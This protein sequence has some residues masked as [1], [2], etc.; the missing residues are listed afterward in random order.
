[1]LSTMT[2][3][4]DSIRM[5]HSYRGD[6]D[7][8]D[9]S[10]RIPELNILSSSS[11]S[12][13]LS[14]S[15][16]EVL[17]KSE[18]ETTLVNGSAGDRVSS[19]GKP[20]TGPRLLSPDETIELARCAVDNGIQETKRS[21]AGSEAV[22]D[23]VKPKLTI[24]LGHSNIV[25]IPEPVV[26]IIKDEVERLSLSGNQLFHIPY[27]FAECSHLRYLNIRANNFR[28]FPKGVY[29]LPLLEI[30]D[31]SRNK[32]SQL[33]EE[34]KKLSSL[35]VLSVMQNRLDD[36]PLG[37]SD[38]NKLQIL[39]VA[40]NPLRN[41]LREL[42][43]TSETDIAPSTMTD[44]EKEVAVT[45]E[46][47][48]FLKN[49]QLSTTP[50]NEKG[51]DASEAIWDTPKPVKRGISSRF[52]VIPSTGDISCDPKSPSL[53]RPPPI[54]L[55][56]HYRI[57][58]GQGIAF[59]SI[60]PRPGTFIPGVNERNRS[61]SEGIIQASIAARSKRMGVIRKNADLGR[62]DETQ[63]YRN[64]HLRGLSHG[65]ILRPRAPGAA[66]SNSS[67]PSSPRERRRLKDSFVNRMSSLPEHKCERK[68]RESIIEC[69]KGVLFALFQVQSHVY[70]LINVIK[71]DDTRRNS[72]EIVFYNASTHVDRLNDALEYAENAQ[73]DDADLVR[74]SNE[75]VK[76]EC[77]T[78]IMA[79]TH[80][81][82]QLRNSL[83]KIVANAD[84]RYVRSLMLMIYS[85]IIELRNACVSLGV[86]LHTCKR[87]SSTKPPIPEI[88]RE[89]VASDRLTAS[90][91]TPTRGRA[92]SLSVRRY[93]SDTT[94]QHPQILT[95]GPL[96]TASNFHSAISSPG[97][98]STP[99]SYAARS[100]SS[101]RSN[102]INTSIPSSLATPRS[103]ESFPPMPSTVVPRINPLT[104]LDEIEE[105][106]TFERI[107]H[108]LTTAYSA[109]LQ[110]LPQTRRQ[111]VRCLELAEQTRESEGIQM[112]WHN[113]IRRCRVCL[114]VSE[115]LGLRLTNMK[116]KE[117]GGGMRN[118]REFWQLCKAFMQSFVDLVTDM[119]EVKSMH[120][121]PSE[122]VM[123]LRPVQRASR[124]AGRLIE[125]SPWSYLADM[126]SGNAP[127][128][129]YGPPL[130][131]QHSQH[132]IST[133]LSPQSVTLPATPLSAALGPAAQATVP[134][135]PASAYSDKFFEGDVFQRADS[136]L[137]M[138]N[139]AP[140][141]S[142][143]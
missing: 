140:F 118:Q 11:S 21:L 36:L 12:S 95:S 127:A 119:R 141:F 92:P 99:F 41:P 117:P 51:N 31:L 53:S 46:L 76:R 103:G 134:S 68:A 13:S 125:G 48:R 121:L 60:L 107:F 101:S 10:R 18:D 33:P 30:L 102:H 20:H 58:S 55:K 40:G 32:I 94:I 2:R 77:E 3:P 39:K 49:K 52:P 17:A 86:P 75:A 98:V 112:L 104:G 34:I 64:S 115:A 4:E 26:D 120:L 128:N 88:N 136:L 15:N 54:P 82:T 126:T 89:M 79:Y 109:A 83:G 80:V 85:S 114:E 65:S 42:L 8:E 110:A 71:R 6:V 44:N 38:M 19:V 37:V 111:F 69:G 87:L 137:S 62:L 106:R 74:L 70:A 129:I 81:G 66:G 50:E 135:T 9:A 67:S 108:Q 5:P 123:F 143:R 28:E 97:F 24:D 14:S 47:K 22:S 122:I 7:E 23:V 45:A 138:P 63:A 133:S 100:R 132:Q 27:R 25:R 105:E 59:N 116:I 131:S 113:L 57:A 130:Q 56:S 90:T 29:K 142:R 43:E 96:Q 93:R 91:V 139:Q 124:E 35:R 72:L 78:C 61:N 16:T 84:S 1:M 73:L